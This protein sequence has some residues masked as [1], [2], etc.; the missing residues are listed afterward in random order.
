MNELDIRTRRRFQQIEAATSER[1]LSTN[2]LSAACSM[3]TCSAC[4]YAKRLTESKRMH[5]EA[6]RET[7]PGH[8]IALYRWGAGRNK[9]KPKPRSKAEIERARLK[10]IRADDDAYDL[11]RAGYR[12]RYA[13]AKA[14]K[15]PNTWL[16]ALGAM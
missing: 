16:S 1:A 7:S 2:E 6:W 9:P 10:R 3:N 15:K 8:W 14:K 11:L 4:Q 13:E 12:A 5:I